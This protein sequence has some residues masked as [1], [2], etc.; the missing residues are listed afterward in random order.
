MDASKPPPWEVLGVRPT[1]SSKEVK[2]AYLRLAKKFHPDTRRSNRRGGTSEDKVR[3]EEKGGSEDFRRVQAAYELYDFPARRWAVGLGR[4]RHGPA[5]AS[6]PS[7]YRARERA[8][9]DSYYDKGGG[10]R[11]GVPPDMDFLGG[12]IQF[13]GGVPRITTRARLTILGF[14]LSLLFAGF[15][16]DQLGRSESTSPPP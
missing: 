1:A 16:Y 14:N 11:Y 6:D 7:D 15:T 12:A 13:R 3:S 2:A 9:R 10:W 5:H 4:F 8:W